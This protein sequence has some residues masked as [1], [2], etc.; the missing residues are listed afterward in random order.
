[1][2]HTWVS[3]IKI[4]NQAVIFI[5]SSL[6]GK[7][8]GSLFHY[9]QHLDEV[10]PGN[11][12][13]DNIHVKKNV[14]TTYNCYFENRCCIAISGPSL[15]ISLFPLTREKGRSVGTCKY[16][17]FFLK[18]GQWIP[19]YEKEPQHDKTNKMICVPSKDSYQAGHPP[20][21]IRVFTVRMTLA[22]QWA[23]S[24]DSDQTGRM[25]R[26][27]QSDLSL[28]WA[29]RSFCWFCHAAAHIITT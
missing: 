29:H 1:M 17:F 27:A 18:E 11:L 13:C 21:L 7:Y 10:D 15:K 12:D 3:L 20:R 28:R 14:L 19:K 23:D 9:A 5:G 6:Q 26:D 4:P 2:H 8:L 25:P 24:E 16:C 22:T